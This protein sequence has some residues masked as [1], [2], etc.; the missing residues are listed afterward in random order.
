[1]SYTELMSHPNKTL[2]EHLENVGNYSKICFENLAIENSDLLSTISFLIGIS[3]DFSKSTSFFQ[4]YLFDHNRNKNAY[5]SFLSSIFTFYVVN[6]YIEKHE[7]NFQENIDII[8]FIIVL[9]HHGNLEDIAELFKKSE[10][11]INSK[12]TN[13]QLNDL[14]SMEVNLKNF[15]NKYDID[16]DYFLENFD[17]ISDNLLD[18]LLD[19]EDEVDNDNYFNNYFIIILLYSVLLDADKMDAS[20]TDVIERKIIDKN[21]VDDYKFSKFNNK[22]SRINDLRERAYENV[23]NNINSMALDNRILSI[24]LPTGMGKTL[25]GFSA[26]IKLKNRINKELNFNPRIIYSLPFLSIIDQN[27]EVIKD[28]L[29]HSNLFGND[30]LIKHNYLSDMIYK[31]TENELDINHSKMLIEGWN[32]EIMIVTFIQFFYSIFSNKNNSLRKFHNIANSIIILDEIQS[33]PFKYWHIINLT[34]KK[35]A[36]DYNCWIILMT[37]TQPLLFNKDEIF[38]LI[39][40]NES[41][42]NE[43]DRVDYNFNIHNQKLEEFNKELISKIECSKKDIMVV[44]NTINSSKEVYENIKEYYTFSDEEISIN[45]DGICEVGEDILLIYISTNIIPKDRL[46]KINEI[47]NSNKRKIIVTTQLIEAGVDIDVDIIYRDFAPLDSIIQTAGRCNRN[48]NKNKGEVNIV[49]LVNE[50][51]RSFSSFI[52][53]SLLRE[54]TKDV[55]SKHTSITE[56]DFNLTASNDYFNEIKKRRAQDKELCNNMRRLNFS[57]I[58]DSFKLI[59]EDYQKVDV[60]IQIDE[61]AKEIFNRFLEIKDNLKGFERKNEFLKIKSDFYNYVISVDEKQI[62]STNKCEDEDLFFV[63]FDDIGRK[64]DVE[65]GFIAQEDEGIFII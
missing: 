17:E 60:F 19:F 43:F 33:I 48:N 51:N 64:Y 16:F 42:F 30:Y 10:D 11:K 28:I 18:K 1:M 3:H 21:I 5:H 41:Y 54:I 45:D 7:I 4:K 31:T 55:L 61:K 9:K 34:L 46:N 38:P 35:L 49:S 6:Q 15:Y 65:E 37:A 12:E 63:S 24:N 59:E 40:N 25:T 8:S 53:D 56:K 52:Y 26:A 39:S 14:R 47:K 58:H 29:N 22:N 44:L 23:I 50:K 13:N 32:S 62:G 57:K 2:E 27:E 36:N 20:Q